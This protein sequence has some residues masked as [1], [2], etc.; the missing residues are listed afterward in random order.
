[1]QGEHMAARQ[2]G[3]L[4]RTCTSRDVWNERWE[5]RRWKPA[6]IPGRAV[7]GGE[8]RTGGGGGARTEHAGCVAGSHQRGVSKREG[9]EVDHGG[10]RCNMQQ[11][12]DEH[13]RVGDE[14]SERQTRGWPRLSRVTGGAVSEPP[15]VRERCAVRRLFSDH[16]GGRKGSGGR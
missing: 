6:V 9:P 5:R 3:R 14:H 7:S 13:G 10:E 4:P 16:V 2:G 8:K 12:E 15:L 1:M 11:E